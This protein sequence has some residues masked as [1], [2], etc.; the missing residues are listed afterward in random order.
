MNVGFLLRDLGKTQVQLA[1]LNILLMTL[2][3]E[4]L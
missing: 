4:K 3:L 2:M 1:A